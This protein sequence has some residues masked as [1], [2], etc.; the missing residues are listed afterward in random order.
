MTRLT[1][2][3]AAID[4]GKGGPPLEASDRLG[5]V[6]LVERDSFL[7]QLDELLGEAAWQRG[8]LVVVRGEAGIGKTSLVEAFTAGRKGRVLWGTCDPVVPPRPLAPIQDIAEQVGGVLQAALEAADRTRILS[9]LLAR[10]RAE[11]GPWVAVLEDL[12]WA[13]EATL[14]VVKV[15][16]RRAAQLRA[17][18]VVTVRDDE[19]G[20]EHPLR[21]ALGDLPAAASVTMQLSP[22]TLEGVA[23]L[24]D[25]SGMDPEALHRITGGN[26]FFVS[27]S[28]A[29]SG[30]EIPL[31]VQDAVLSR[32]QRL[33][34]AGVQ[35][36]RA[37][38]VLGPRCDLDILRR[39]ADV[40]PDGVDE[41]L[42]RGLLCSSQSV[43][44]FRHELA[45]LA[46]L[47]SI[48]A[49]ERSALHRRALEAL[50][51]HDRS[52]EL[53]E[54]ARHA[55]AGGDPAA[56][57]DLAPRAGAEAAGL[58]AHRAAVAYYESALRYSGQLPDCDRASLLAAYAHECLV[59][60]R[61]DD[62]V[63]SQEAALALRRLNDD[64]RSEGL[65]L[66]DLA[67]YLFWQGEP[68][69]AIQSATESVGL[70][71][72]IGPDASV[73]RAYATLASVLM[74]SGQQTTARTWA[75]KAV[76]LGERL[77]EES[78]AVHALNTLG[79][80]E[81]LL[82]DDKGWG[83]LEES[84][85]RAIA[86]NLEEDI[87]RAYIN[88]IA[89][90]REQRRYDQF[91]RY[92]EEAA[93][94]FDEHDRDANER[95][96]AGDIVEGLFER[97]RWSDAA[98]QAGAV[99]AR[100]SIHGR[101]QCVAVL[102]R[103]GARRGDADSLARLDDAL[104][105]NS[106]YGGE[107]MYPLRAARAEAAL[108]RGDQQMAAREIAAG[109]DNFDERSNPW[110]VGEF[111][112]WARKSGIDWPCPT[113]PAEP[114]AFFLDG[115]PAKA[116]AAWA[117]LGCPYDE[118]LC[119]VDCDE[120]SEVERALSIFQSLGA[121]PAVKMATERL[122][123]MGVRRVRRGPRATTRRNP[124][125]LS[126][127]E[128]EVLA[129]LAGGKRNSEIAERLVLSTRTVDHHVSAILAKLE[130]RSRYEAGRKAAQLGIESQ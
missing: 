115:H 34:P 106:R 22:L 33:S 11:G 105:L 19:V 46:V 123:S 114:Y 127:R 64:V 18:V 128:V 28:L 43:V 50:L 89:S 70:L 82:Q 101:A 79:T 5:A 92:S 30:A 91:D 57:L 107:H 59:V 41:C 21:G 118:A 20:P 39:V 119:L 93:V 113:P 104:T 103:L 1:S 26:P 17:V 73:A 8:R 3:I 29:A 14:D 61:V 117:V 2:G 37:A 80:A 68:D 110:H 40:E 12:Q 15:I 74:R 75:A 55:V 4:V 99:V 25:G 72:A 102:G 69:R 67:E 62:A 23:R 85:Q 7:E 97:G 124:A 84:L 24:A 130:V 88:L 54:L 78:I 111:A 87:C 77:G 58:G 65:A 122:Q 66:A 109:Q 100:G 53:T 49:S 6:G 10:L 98:A 116:A 83:K 38:S 125:G 56:T 16:G 90:S 9:A 129:L 36:A 48:P 95:C 27:E 60:D 81:T 51:Q 35:A 13:D 112:F 71:E 94:F 42:G 76:E 63:K 32:L 86:A 120:V 121:S 52:T 47:E 108:L 45:R 31:T 96:L 44:E 126:D